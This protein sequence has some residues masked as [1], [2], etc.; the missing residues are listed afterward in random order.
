MSEEGGR[1]VVVAT[2]IGNLGDLSPRARET[3][4]SADLIAC[5]DTRHSR[6]LLTAANIRARRLVA[7]HAHNEAARTEELMKRLLGGEVV[8]LICDAG[9]PLVSDPGSRL[10]AAAVGAGVPVSSVPGPSA[11]LAALVVSGFDLTRFHFEG[12]L[13]RKG[14]ERRARLVAMAR[15][16]E[17]WVVYESPKRVASSL[18][19]LAAICG[20]ERRVLVARELTKRFEE[21]WR[22]GLAAAAEWAASKP[23]RGEYVLVVDAA[24]AGPAEPED[25]R[26]ALARLLD[27]GLSRRDAVLAAEILLGAAHRDAYAAS[28]DAMGAEGSPGRPVR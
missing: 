23:A 11:L 10:V 16:D 13:P 27:A 3:L 21:L 6:V 20:A 19:E 2:P 25:L 9:T 5:E 1:L 24:E 17:P 4:A 15:A 8:A 18:E 22:G 28:L 12:F 7:L 14:E 26:G